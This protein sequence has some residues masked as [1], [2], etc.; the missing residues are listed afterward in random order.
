MGGFDWWDPGVND[1]QDT[2]SIKDTV[3]SLGVLQET[4]SKYLWEKYDV[5]GYTYKQS[6]C[7]LLIS[8]FG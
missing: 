2:H 3:T 1:Q 5:T 7:W 8:Q 4:E 6:T